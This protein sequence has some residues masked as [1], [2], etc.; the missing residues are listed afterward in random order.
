MSSVP[1]F[2]DNCSFQVSQEGEDGSASAA[3]EAQ[4]HHHLRRQ[5]GGDLGGLVVSGPL[6]GQGGGPLDSVVEAIQEVWGVET[7]FCKIQSFSSLQQ[8]ISF[9]YLNLAPMGARPVL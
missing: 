6:R 3:A 5:E 1:R 9:F 2:V 8:I 4:L 7:I